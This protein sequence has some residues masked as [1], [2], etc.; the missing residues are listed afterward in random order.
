MRRFLYGLICLAAALATSPS[1]ALDLGEDVTIAGHDA[2]LWRTTNHRTRRPTG[3]ALGRW[4]GVEP[5]RTVA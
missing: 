2:T 4:A 1:H 3:H 5:G